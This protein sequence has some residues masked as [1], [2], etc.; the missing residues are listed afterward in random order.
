MTN[1]KNL[2]ITIIAEAGVNHNG[3]IKL[4]YK[5]VDMAKRCG[6]DFIKFQTSIPSMHIS[7]HALKAKYQIKNTGNKQNQLEMS[8]KISLSYDEFKKISNYCKKKKINF[9]STAFDLQSIDFLK[10][11]RMKFFKI[12][13][14]EITNLPYL[15]KIGKLKKKI[16]ISTGMSNLKEINQA[17]KILM[18]GGTKKSN[19]TVM[20][21]NTEYPTPL[22][23]AN[24]KAML[25]IKNKF[26]V[27]VGYS[28]HTLG[29][30]ASIWAAAMGAKIIEKHITL[31]KSLQGPDHKASIEERDLKLLVNKVRLLEIA[32]GNGK[33]EPTK[34][35]KKNI[36]IARN[37]LVAKCE[38]KKG[39][40]FSRTNITAKRPG[41]GISPMLVDKVLGKIAQ[42]N[43]EEDEL[44]K[45]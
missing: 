38:I 31:D 2:S 28:D 34:S 29:V 10:S 26:K 5:L 7:K 14:G 37:S 18:R 23:D 22:K 35:E 33:K 21:C 15:L 25:T 24:L 40:R 1:K 42:K 12:P 11:F 41:N 13:S 9:L 19:I 17:L 30:D 44:I 3:N 6:A 43:F 27:N 16:I 8:K 36:V 32:F 20:Q 4:A 45:I 39:Q